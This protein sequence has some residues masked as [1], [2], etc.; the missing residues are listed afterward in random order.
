MRHHF[1]SAD[2]LYESVGHC[3]YEKKR[4]SFCKK[5]VKTLNITITEKVITF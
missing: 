5:G 2:G 4:V 1:K 3:L